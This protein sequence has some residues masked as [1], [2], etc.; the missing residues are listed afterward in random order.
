MVAEICGSILSMSWKRFVRLLCFHCS[1][2]WKFHQFI[3]FCRSYLKWL[4]LRSS[5]LQDASME[6][7]AID[8][9]CRMFQPPAGNCNLWINLPSPGKHSKRICITEVSKHTKH[10]VKINGYKKWWKIL[11][12]SDTHCFI[13]FIFSSHSFW[14][15][16]LASGNEP[17][18]KWKISWM[19][20]IR[21][22]MH[23]PED[24]TE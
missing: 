3:F 2:L 21:C 18:K 5:H 6:W 17:W 4:I 13:H 12:L 11:L 20:L 16:N 14:N 22:K 23:S 8:F 9:S 24:T 7:L 10:I 15:S 19:L 1:F